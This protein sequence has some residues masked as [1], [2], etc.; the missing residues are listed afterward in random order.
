MLALSESAGCSAKGSA[1]GAGSGSAGG[2]GVER[3]EDAEEEAPKF[4]SLVV[5]VSPPDA[6]VRIV[7][8]PLAAEGLLKTL[9]VEPTGTAERRYHRPMGDYRVRVT[10]DGYAD[11]DREI[12]LTEH[13][14]RISIELARQ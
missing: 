9:R 13:A 2:G 3:D 8:G 11:A 6:E 7:G 5:A 4:G 1:G 12:S 14:L 10:R